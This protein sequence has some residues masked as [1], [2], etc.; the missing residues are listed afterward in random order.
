MTNWTRVFLFVSQCRDPLHIWDVVLLCSLE[1]DFVVKTRLRSGCFFLSC[2]DHSNLTISH[3]DPVKFLFYIFIFYG[4]LIKATCKDVW[5]LNYIDIQDLVKHM[6]I[7]YEGRFCTLSVHALF[8]WN[9]HFICTVSIRGVIHR[10][11]RD[12]VVCSGPFPTAHRTRGKT[13]FLH[14]RRDEEKAV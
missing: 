7:C 1:N 3:R 13:S 2:K 11:L 5:A 8:P 4:L 14:W 12:L 10:P 9:P 6:A